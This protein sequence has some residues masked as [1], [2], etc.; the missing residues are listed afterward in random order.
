MRKSS[1]SSD[2]LPRCRGCAARRA[3]SV[4]PKKTSAPGPGRFG[5]AMSLAL[6]ALS[7]A[8]AAAEPEEWH[9]EREV[10]Q[11]AA[12]SRSWDDLSMF[13]WETMGDL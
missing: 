12:A 10:I 9:G 8:W 4:G 3:C 2:G 1:E 6:L 13:F 11:V 7:V 5:V